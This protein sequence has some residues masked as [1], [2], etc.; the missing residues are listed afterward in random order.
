[1]YHEIKE[2]AL[3]ISD[4]HDNETRDGF[5]NFL[6]SL[7]A[8][9]TLPPQLFL[10][11]DMFELLVGEI[12]Y[13]KSLFKETIELI[14]TLSKD[15]EIFYFEGNHDFNLQN[16]FPNVQIFSIKAQPK[17]FHFINQKVLLSHGDLH[18]G[19]GYSLYTTIIRNNITLKILNFIDTFTQNAISKKILSLHLNKDICYKVQDFQQITKLKLKKYDIGITDIDFV[20]EGHHHQNKEFVFETL[21]YKNF[22]SFACDKSYYKITFEDGIKFKELF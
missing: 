15:I 1:M 6:K 14:N 5:Y 13:T 18:Q 22:S 11:G 17:L 3:F 19:M 8:S 21:K 20:C 2:G 16:I 9:D 4:A 10:M 7:N 12:T